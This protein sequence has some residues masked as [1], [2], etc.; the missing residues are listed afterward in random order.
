MLSGEESL[1]SLMM[2]FPLTLNSILHRAETIHG[3]REVVT[4]MP[5]RSW[6][7]Y[8]YRDMSDRAKRLAL[9]LSNLGVEAGDRV[10][11]L[12]WNHYR[13][14]ETY[15]GI[16]AYGAVLHTLNPRLHEDDLVHIISEA[17]DK[18]LILDESLLPVLARFR[19][20]INLEHVIVIAEGGELPEGMH[21]YETLLSETDVND[22]KY[23]E[24]DENQA[25][26][27]CYTSGT[28]GKP[29]GVVYSHRAI[30]LHSLGAALTC[31]FE[32]WESDSILPVVPMFHVNGWGLPYI[33]AMM[34]SKLVLP[35]PSL[36][37]VSLLE[38]YEQ[39][40]VTFTAGVP[41][42]WLAL[43]EKLDEDPEKYDVSAL[44]K[45]IVGGAAMPQ[46][47][48]QAFQ[49]R[50]NLNLVAAWGM[51]ETTPMGTIC[52]LRPGQ[53]EASQDEQYG[54]R[55][56]Q[57]TPVPFVEIRARGP[58]GLVEWDGKTMG[59]LE[60]RGPWITSGYHNRPDT[61]D[62]ITED[63]WFRTGDIVSINKRGSMKIEDRSKDLIKSGGEWISS[64]D[65]ENAIMAHEDVAEA[66]VIAIDHPKWGERPLAAVVARPESTL[67]VEELQEFL[68]SVVAKWWIP[69]AFE[70]VSEIP[71]TATGKFNKV[72]LREQFARR[73]V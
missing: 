67:N 12:C 5:D 27:M 30:A 8:G 42:M 44:R 47:L 22:F 36:D 34:G 62:R 45:L 18:I 72:A 41:T 37:A 16:P 29:K 59:E 19:D 40:Q 13:H 21:S 9:A 71:K 69:D 6:H 70:I 20:R 1:N 61:A 24:I 14:L 2:D 4:R 60:V 38:A 11:T 73:S 48:L 15:F 52:Y 23:P 26:S 57:G 68:A 31:G 49:E 25:A 3:E 39:E 28:V 43:L 54:Y 63:G 64:V 46:S 35:G 53:E 56:R 7:R 50:H 66:A 51:T 10:A 17:G 32:I 55:C 65:L 58:N 33:A